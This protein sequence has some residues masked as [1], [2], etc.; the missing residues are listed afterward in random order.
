MDQLD[1]VPI[2]AL[3]HY[4]YCPRQCA[5][6]HIEQTFD[7]NLYTLRGRRVHENV[8]V[9][10]GEITSGVRVEKALPLYSQQYGLVGKADVVEFHLDGTPHPVEYKSGPRKSRWADEVQLCGQAICLE[11]M[12]GHPVSKGS[13]YFHRSRRRREVEIDSAK[14]EKVLAIIEEVR[15]L[16]SSPKL[17]PPVADSRCDK[18]SL[19]ESCMPFALKSFS[20]RLKQAQRNR[21]SIDEDGEADKI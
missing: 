7:E 18:C 12:T 6:I 19:L 5:M 15:T 1:L 21:E 4:V 17:P 13:L 2:S 10:E 11:E 20:Q 3:Q 16:L 14:K 9:P 8:D